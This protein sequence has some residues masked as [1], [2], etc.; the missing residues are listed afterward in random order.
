MMRIQH[1][2]NEM[3]LEQQGRV[4]DIRSLL[5]LQVKFPRPKEKEDATPRRSIKI[6]PESRRSN[7][8]LTK[9][10]ADAVQKRQERLKLRAK[11]HNKELTRDLHWI[12]SSG[13]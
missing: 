12:P 5:G 13:T 3:D 4:G 10:E 7:P 6:D 2:K 9:R 11:M 8:L 1:V